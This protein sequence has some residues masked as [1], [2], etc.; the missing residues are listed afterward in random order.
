MHVYGAVQTFPHVP[1]L[2]LMSSSRQ[3]PPQYGGKSNRTHSP[4]QQ[5][6]NSL[7]AEF[8]SHAPQKAGFVL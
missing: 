7:Q 2:R 5:S 4:K 6:S 3:V 1:Q 8:K